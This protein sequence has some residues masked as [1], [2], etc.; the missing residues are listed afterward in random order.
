MLTSAT[1]IDPGSTTSSRPA[2]RA[3]PR[4]GFY[5]AVAV[6][7]TFSMVFGGLLLMAAPAAAQSATTTDRV[8]LRTGPGLE[9]DVIGLMPAGAS[10]TVDGA[11]ENGYFPVTYTGISGYASAAFISVGGGSDIVGQDGADG[12]DG[13]DGQDGESV[14]SEGAPTGSA[15]V[16]A[17]RL[18]FRSGPSLGDGVIS[19]LSDGDAV[20]L[21]GQQSNGY[22][23]AVANGTTG[24]LAAD[25]LTTDGAPSEPAS[26]PDTDRG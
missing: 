11:V 7:T 18:N 8:N 10:L 25:F 15:W 3:Q 23:Q 22:W 12:Q 13:T 5:R 4:N 16:T 20:E 1:T 21:T 24:W 26:D 6:I 17:D 2:K 9:F 19:V 14:V